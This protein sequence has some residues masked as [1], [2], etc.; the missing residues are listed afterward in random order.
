MFIALFAV[1]LIIWLL[2]W[3]TFHVTGGLIHLLVV[4]ALISLVVLAVDLIGPFVPNRPSSRP[5]APM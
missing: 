2:A 4:F 5:L 3:L 1:L